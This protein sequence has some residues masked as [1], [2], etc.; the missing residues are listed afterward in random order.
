VRRAIL[1]SLAA[2]LVLVAAAA[3]APTLGPEP[4]VPGTARTTIFYYPWWGTPA[5]DGEFVHWSQNGAA[6]PDRIASAFYPARGPYSS[7]DARILRAHMRDIRRAGVD[8]LATS[9]WGWG[10][11]EDRQLPAILAA[12]RAESL[13][14]AVHIEPYAGRTPASVAAD[15]GHLRE[16][17]I[18][19]FYVYGAEG[20]P[21]EEWGAANAGIDPEARV[22]A[23]TGLAG[24]AAAGGFEGVYTYDVLVYGGPRFARLCE[25]A[26]RKQLLCGPSVGPGYNALRA[27]GDVRLKP[28]REGRTYDAMWRA[29]ISA[30]AD[31]VTVTSYNEWHEGTQIEPARRRLG[32]GGYDGAW[33]L[34]G[35][36]AEH[37]Y[38]DRTAYWAARFRRSV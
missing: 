8:Q 15:I 20:T 3:A 34:R 33:G 21:A 5:H 30:G 17:G 6:P 14:V 9:W 4:R 16:L 23:Q 32:F 25:Q 13:G 26:H 11:L 2:S 29:A 31:V 10:S 36:A 24:F 18:L 37:A 38:V 7:R 22:F 19:D 1:A 28:R 12:A 35:A 27:V